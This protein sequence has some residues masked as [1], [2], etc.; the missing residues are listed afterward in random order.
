MEQ[1]IKDP[2]ASLIIP[3]VLALI[4]F[5]TIFLFFGS[6]PDKLPLFYSLPWGDNQ[7]ASHNQFYI[8]PAVIVTISLINFGLAHQLHPTQSF[9]KLL[10]YSSSIILSLILTVTFIK[11]ILIYL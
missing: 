6:L 11:I 3:A 5:L 8:I 1:F 4:T 10:L 9:F 7:L 2:L